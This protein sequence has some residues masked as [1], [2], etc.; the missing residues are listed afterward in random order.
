[1]ANLVMLSLKDGEPS[2]NCLSQ[3]QKV[4][5]QLVSTLFLQWISSNKYNFLTHILVSPDTKS[6]PESTALKT[7]ILSTWSFNPT[8]NENHCEVKPFHKLGKMKNY[9]IYIKSTC[10]MRNDG[11][12]VWTSLMQK[13]DTQAYGHKDSPLKS[14]HIQSI[15]P[16][17]L[18]RGRKMKQSS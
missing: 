18:Y 4:N 16:S 15:A 10:N 9:Q 14:N 2:L 3:P 12:E 1:M 5:L 17:P 11:G 7:D 13:C 6:N 8:I